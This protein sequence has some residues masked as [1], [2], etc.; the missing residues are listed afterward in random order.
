MKRSLA[1]AGA[2]LLV[3]SAA[4]L[5]A[6]CSSASTAPPTP[7]GY[8]VTF[9]SI[10]AAIAAESVTLYVYDGSQSCVALLQAVQTGTLSNLA[11]PLQ[12]IATSACT[13]DSPD[14]GA[15]ALPYGTYAVVAVA[16]ESAG[17]APFLDGCTVA[18]LS[19]ASPSTL[20][21]LDVVSD[22]VT[23]PPTPAS[24]SGL[25][26]YCA[27]RNVADAACQRQLDDAG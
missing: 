5:V 26:A 12:T 2:S 25:G 19:A 14:A 10:G 13:L 23:V 22:A 21:V 4:S 27:T 8:A 20:V 17:G 15:I 9:P 24:C 6:S 16:A 18:T 7:G 1:Y 3:V 11:A